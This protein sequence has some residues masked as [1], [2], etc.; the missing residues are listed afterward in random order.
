MYKLILNL[1]IMKRITV[2]Q[3]QAFVGKYLTQAQA[4]EILATAQI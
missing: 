1:W 4:D 3:I 2:E